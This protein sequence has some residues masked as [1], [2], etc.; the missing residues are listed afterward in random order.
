[1]EEQIGKI[2]HYFAKISVGIIEVV[3]GELKVGDKIHIKGHTSDFF[4]VVESMQSEH[5]SVAG[6]KAGDSVG[7]KVV[8]PVHEHDLVFKVQP[9]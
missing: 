8:S 2:S 1:M 5:K 6:A 7:I 9:D 3:K 4:Q